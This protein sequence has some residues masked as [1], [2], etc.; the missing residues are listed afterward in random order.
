MG[1]LWSGQGTVPHTTVS[2]LLSTDVL[3]SPPGTPIGAI[4]EV[5]KNLIRSTH[6]VLCLGHIPANV[7]IAEETTVLLELVPKLAVKLTVQLLPGESEDKV[8]IIAPPPL[9]TLLDSDDDVDPH[10]S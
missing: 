8:C 9:G 1:P 6:V 5:P 7:V 3:V 2:D 10:R 4:M